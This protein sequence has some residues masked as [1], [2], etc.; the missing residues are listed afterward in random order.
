VDASIVQRTR[1]AQRRRRGAAVRWPLPRSSRLPLL[2]LLLLQLLLVLARLCI[3]LRAP[4][5][6]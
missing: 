5:T 2:L 6:K 1:G 3:S 4:D